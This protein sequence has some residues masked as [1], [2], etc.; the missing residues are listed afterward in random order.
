MVFS[1]YV[2]L[3]QDF[4]SKIVLRFVIECRNMKLEIEGHTKKNDKNIK[5]LKKL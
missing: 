5:N 1:K 3:E 2:K 4:E